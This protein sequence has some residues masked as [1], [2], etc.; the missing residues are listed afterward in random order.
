VFINPAEQLSPLLPHSL[1]SCLAP[2]P[3]DSCPDC[4]S[5][6]L[7]A[8][9]GY[10]GKPLLAWQMQGTAAARGFSAPH[11]YGQSKLGVILLSRE[12]CDR[13]AAAGLPVASVAVH[14]GVTQQGLER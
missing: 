3:T 9:R 7:P 13:A 2:Q 6:Y 1:M 12:L 8:H 10:G 14:P 4:T 11:A 5:I